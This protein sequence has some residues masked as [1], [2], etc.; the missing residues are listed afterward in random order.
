MSEPS[1]KLP[2]HSIEAEMCALASLMLAGDDQALIADIRAL[3]APASFFQ[4][5]HETIVQAMY[6]VLDAGRKI[7]AV[8]L[9][10]EL[11]RRDLLEDVGGVSY[12][13]R[14]LASV[15]NAA[16]GKHYAQIVREKFLLRRAA[17]IGLKLYRD[18]HEAAEHDRACELID[19]GLTELAKLNASAAAS[20]ITTIASAVQDAYLS[21]EKGDSPLIKLGIGPIDDDLGGIARGETVVIGARP[22]MGKSTLMRQI[23]YSAA[24]MGT[25]VGIISLEESPAKI[26]RNL[27]SAVASVENSR[28]RLGQVQPGEWQSLAE[29][30]AAISD[31]PI[32][33][34]SRAFTLPAIRSVAAMMVARYGIKILIVDYLQ[35]VKADGANRYEQVTNASAGITQLVKELNVAG[36]LLAQLNRAL[37][38]RTDKR[39]TMSDLRESG[40]IE[41]DADAI[42]F[43]HREDYYRSTGEAEGDADGVAELIKSKYRDGCRGGT[44]YL[45]SNLRY[46][47]FDAPDVKPV[48]DPFE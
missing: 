29:G 46:Q 7:D 27:L 16:N 47:R 5:D 6:D 23:A 22:S 9:R 28:L 25:P 3:V 44:I 18:V 30:T 45:K 35:K 20:E 15:P 13:A 43:L 41:Q 40:Q 42:L 14:L 24:K 11:L 48:V 4:P 34:A 32:Y 26:S 38:G 8:I 12:L 36:V 33:V 2:P 1:D 31:L 10:E 21:L 17:T 19:E 37:T 39:P